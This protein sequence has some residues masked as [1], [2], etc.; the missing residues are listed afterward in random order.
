MDFENSSEPDLEAALKDIR[1]VL[2]EARL[3][4][5]FLINYSSELLDALHIRDKKNQDF[6]YAMFGLKKQPEVNLVDFTVYFERTRNV[7]KPLHITVGLHDFDDKFRHPR[8]VQR[9]LAKQNITLKVEGQVR[10]RTISGYN[11]NYNLVGESRSGIISVQF[12]NF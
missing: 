11:A 3:E 12:G 4:S 1:K 10:Y 8:D 6:V 7:W 5:N 2:K 9:Y